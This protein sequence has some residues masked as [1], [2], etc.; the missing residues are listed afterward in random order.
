MTADTV[1]IV[2]AS[3]DIAADYVVKAL[4]RRGTPVFRLNTDH[5][6]SQVKASFRSS[7]DIEFS[8]GTETLKGVSVKSVWYRRHVSPELPT[9]LET[10]VR[11]F[12]ERETRAFLEGILSALPVKRWMSRRQ[13]LIQAEKKPYQLAIATHLGFTVPETLITNDKSDVLKLARRRELIAKAVSSGYIS[14][15]DGNRAIFTHALSPD[16][17]ENLDGLTLAPVTFQE[18]VYKISDIRVTVIGDEVFAAEI[19]SQ[20]EESS[21]IDWRATEDPQLP[22]RIHKLPPEIVNRCRELVA[23]LGLAFGAL[24][25][26]LKPD[27]A[28]IFF[29]I[30]PNGEWVWLEDQLGFP[31]SDRIAK[32]LDSNPN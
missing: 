2:T 31:I 32:W 12:C 29:E 17:L 25:F 28:Y 27:G 8:V 30:N 20:G 10:G 9:E 23:H 3:Y 14:Y 21:R 13:A 1:L 22:H 7:G 4:K 6:P 24:D 5:F 16:D 19:L 18:L 15:P 11:N 26:A